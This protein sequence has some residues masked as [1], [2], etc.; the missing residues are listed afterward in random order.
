VP[1]VVGFNHSRPDEISA[2]TGGPES[3][4]TNHY[5]HPSYFVKR[6]YCAE[7]DYYSLGVVL[8][9]IGLW[10]PLSRI[11]RKQQGSYE[12]IRQFLIEK[13]LPVLRRS[14]GR[15][16]YEA[17]KICLQ[18]GMEGSELSDGQQASQATALSLQFSTI[19]VD[20]LAKLVERL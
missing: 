12:E 18:S 14:M 7:Y 13:R 17:V 2:F 3:S 20:R 5:Q 19:V 8:L 10:A 6:R 9:E 11:I 4:A 16:Y 15:Q 1:Y